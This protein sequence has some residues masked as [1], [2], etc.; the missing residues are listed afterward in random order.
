M[1]N[2]IDEEVGIEDS[3]IS[4]AAA[5]DQDARWNGLAGFDRTRA[6]AQTALRGSPSLTQGPYFVDEDLNRSDIRFDPTDRTLQARLDI[7]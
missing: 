7:R 1:K 4:V 6:L 3:G 5:V 2:L